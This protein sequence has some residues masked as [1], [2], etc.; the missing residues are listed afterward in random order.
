MFNKKIPKKIHLTCRD[1]NNID[2]PVWM[3]CIKKYK[4][5]YEDYE[6]I[7]YDNDDIYNIIGKYFPNHLNKVK[8]IKIGA[9]LAD[10]F[11]YLI[12]YLE[13][14]IYSDMDCEPIIKIDNLFIETH[15]HCYDH[16]NNKCND[17][18][19]FTIGNL[20]LLHDYCNNH[21]F[22][23]IEDDNHNIYECLGHKYENKN[24]YIGTE[25]DKIFYKNRTI[26]QF[27]QWFIIAKPN[28]QLF[29]D[30]YNECISNIDKLINLNKNDDNYQHIVL[31]TSGPVMFTKIVKK[32]LPSDDICILPLDYLCSNS[33][34]GVSLTKNSYIKHVFT[35]SWK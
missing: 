16:C 13:G 28:E 10:I 18:N 27:C 35:G 29:L 34:C 22:I 15:Y 6:I 2:N 14:G 32:Y 1:K 3:N 17:N 8:Q 20:N 11:R 25:I 9:V 21:K 19:C 31:T 33:H 26:H 30:S 5:M 24:I 4:E 7:I 23:K 12:L